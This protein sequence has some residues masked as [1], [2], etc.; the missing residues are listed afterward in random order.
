MISHA[1]PHQNQHLKI[2]MLSQSKKE[3]G[4]EGGHWQDFCIPLVKNKLINFCT[5]I[6][7]SRDCYSGA[8]AR[9]ARQRSTMGK[10]N[11]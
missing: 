9:E 4:G 1:D 6:Q 3:G 10:K 11:W 5:L 2:S 7:R 8:S